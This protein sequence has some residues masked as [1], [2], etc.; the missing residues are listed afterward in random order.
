M[1]F[2]NTYRDGD[3]T[4]SLGSMAEAVPSPLPS[5]CLGY[6][7]PAVSSKKRAGI[8]SELAG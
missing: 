2:L 6:P 8:F 7:A 3:F 1:C 4:A 5:F